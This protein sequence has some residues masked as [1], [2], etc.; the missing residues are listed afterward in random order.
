M[1]S[2]ARISV[3]NDTT[4]SRLL[5]EPTFRICNIDPITGN[6][7][8]NAITHPSLVDGNLT[9]YF[10]TVDTLKA[11]INMPLNHPNKSLPFPASDDDDRGG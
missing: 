11:Y 9:I 10:E 3:S 6:D 5:H 7:I 1:F 2:R 8:P 4:Q